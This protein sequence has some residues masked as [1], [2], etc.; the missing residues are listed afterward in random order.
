LI[1]STIFK[2]AHTE[3]ASENTNFFSTLPFP[4]AAVAI[5]A[6]FPFLAAGGGAIFV[7]AGPKGAFLLLP[8]AVA[9]GGICDWRNS[10]GNGKAKRREWVLKGNTP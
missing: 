8:V 5:F 10:A 7:S 9:L 6:V 4:L 1:Q 2:I 3:L